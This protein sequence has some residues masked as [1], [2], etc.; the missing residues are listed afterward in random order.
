M[1]AV[2]FRRAGPCR[3]DG[4]RRAAATASDGGDG[5]RRP[6]GRSEPPDHP[7]HPDRP[8]LAR[9]AAADRDHPRSG[10]TWTGC[11]R[12]CGGGHAPAGRRGR[13][14]PGWWSSPASSMQRLRTPCAA[15]G[16]P[17]RGTRSPRAR[18]CVPRWRW[19]GTPW[20]DGDRVDRR[21][22]VA[23]W[24]AGAP[25]CWWSWPRSNWPPAGMP[26]R[27][28]TCAVG[29]P[30]TRVGG[31]GVLPGDR[32][33]SQRR[34]G[35]RPGRMPRLHRPLLHRLRPGRRARL[36]APGERPAQPASPARPAPGS[37]RR[38]AVG[39]DRPPG[40][41]GCHHPAAGR[42][43]AAGVDRAGRASGHRRRAP[44]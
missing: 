6:V 40:T 3:G 18:C 10:C 30:S 34:P 27:S 4:G 20:G 37:R 19:R 23:I 17:P 44:C 39:P 11:G 24:R 13:G 42:G 22:P 43:A 7:G 41:R 8:G 28:P 35:G 36:P 21:D 5:A 25:N 2:E 32:A 12:R 15:A 33:L 31:A 1:A 9:P 14:L 38:R 26:P 16:K 29:A